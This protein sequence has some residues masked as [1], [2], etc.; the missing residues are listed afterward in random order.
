[1]FFTG[2]ICCVERRPS[3]DRVESGRAVRKHFYWEMM[4][5]WLRIGAVE[6]IRAAV[7]S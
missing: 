7:Y 5:T 4:V 6:V 2:W 1:M 3:G